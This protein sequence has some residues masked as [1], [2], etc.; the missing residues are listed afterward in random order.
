MLLEPYASLPMVLGREI[1]GLVTDAPAGSGFSTGQ[2]VVVEPVLDCACR[3]LPPCR[4]CAKGEYNLCENF[5]DGA[6][7]PGSF[8]GFNSQASGGMAEFTAAHPSK[9]LPVPDGLSDEDAILVDS[10]ASVMQPILENFPEPGDTVLIWG[11]GVL[12]QH[13]VRGLRALGFA[14][15]LVAVARHQFQADL[16][17]AGGADEV[18]RSPSRKELARACGGNSSPP[19]WV[20]ATWRAGRTWSS[21]AWPH[22]ARSRNRSWPF[23]PGAAT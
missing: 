6:L 8:L 12:G 19:P 16:M 18:L 10:M 15:R 7:A 11:A 20:G 14:G 9:V 21:T 1:L 23:E 17:R 5:L 13:A 2:R 22:R 3:E 4:F